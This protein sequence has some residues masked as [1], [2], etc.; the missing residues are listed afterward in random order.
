MEAVPQLI[1]MKIE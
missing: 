1:K